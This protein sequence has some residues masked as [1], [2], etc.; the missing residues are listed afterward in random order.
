MGKKLL[1]LFILILILTSCSKKPD[2]T[3][4]GV[5]SDNFEK[6]SIFLTE[7]EYEQ[8]QK[9][10]VSNVVSDYVRRVFGSSNELLIKEIGGEY[11]FG[12]AFIEFWEGE[13]QYFPL[14]GLY[15]IGVR[16]DSK[17]GGADYY[18]LEVKCYLDL[19]SIRIDSI[20]LI[21]NSMYVYQ[22]TTTK[23]YQDA[24]Y[25]KETITEWDVPGIKIPLT[26]DYNIERVFNKDI[27]PDFTAGGLY[28]D[29]YT[30]RGNNP[31][32]NIDHS[33]K[34]KPELSKYVSN[35]FNSYVENAFGQ[36][37]SIT[38]TRVSW[39]ADDKP[40]A[41]R[42]QKISYYAYFDIVNNNA[43]TSY[44][45]QVVCILGSSELEIT[46]VNINK[47]LKNIKEWNDIG[48]VLP[49]Y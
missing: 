37:Y 5:Y 44:G 21:A 13:S 49:I 6:T 12:S 11:T 26:S 15:V 47:N 43:P 18:I 29:K 32:V 14:P 27:N 28:S 48:I 36:E 42:N 33:D 4:G 20:D 30:A 22:N 38:S 39:G 31:N 35:V 7:E 10:L 8:G 46:D 2:F 24:F 34:I 41:D 19:D 9:K 16:I 17:D 45:V 25:E 3:A 23:K 40:H 1:F